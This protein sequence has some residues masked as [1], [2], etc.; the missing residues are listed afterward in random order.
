MFSLKL[1]PKPVNSTR[2]HHDLVDRLLAGDAAGAAA[3]NR[4]HRERAS[5]ELLAIFERYKLAQ[6]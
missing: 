4:S 6:M 2:E 3:V 5:R 1:P